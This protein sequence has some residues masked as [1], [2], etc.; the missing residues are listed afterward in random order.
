M[1]SRRNNLTIIFLVVGIGISVL[2]GGYAA[3]ADRKSTDQI[4]RSLQ[5]G[6][7]QA[8]GWDSDCKNYLQHGGA[9]S[10][11]DYMNAY[12][13]SGG[14][15]IL[16]SEG[17]NGDL[18]FPPYHDNA[19]GYR[20]DTWMSKRGQGNAV[21]PISVDYG[22]TSIPLQ[23]NDVMFLCGPL[24]NPDLAGIYHHGCRTNVSGAD[25][26]NDS[27]RWVRADD[28]NDRDPNGVVEGK[29]DPGSGCMYPAQS[30]SRRKVVSLVVVDSSWGGSA[31]IDVNNPLTNCGPDGAA[32]YG[33]TC[34]NIWRDIHSRYWIAPPVNF[35]Y[36][37]GRPID[38]SGTL[39]IQLHYKFFR[40][41]HSDIERN[42]TKICEISGLKVGR[43][44]Y[45]DI[46]RCPELT[47]DLYL[48]IVLNY[49]YTLSPGIATSPALLREGNPSIQ[50]Q[51][52][53]NNTGRT[54]SDNVHWYVSRFVVPPGGTY[55]KSD[56][57]APACT[58]F[59]G[60]APGSCT[61]IQDG[62]RT[63]PIG[64][65]YVP[66]PS[67]TDT[68]PGGTPIGS[69]ICYVTSVDKGST[70][71]PT[72]S[73]SSVSC[74]MIERIPFVQV[75][76][77]DLRVGSSFNGTNSRAGATSFVFDD[78]GSW[79]EY[80]ILAPGGVSGLASESA[81]H[82]GNGGAP[83]SWSSLTFANTGVGLCPSS[84]GCFD[85]ATN[86]G[87]IPSVG[88]FVKTATYKGAPLNYDQGSASF[89]ASD[90]PSIVSGTNL[91]S[92]TKAFSMT[93]T[94]D[95]TID[96]DITYA[97]GVLHSTGEIPQL[98]L[99]GRNINITGNVK[100]ID[101]WLVA[102]GTVNTCSD[103]AQTAL[104]A[105][106]CTNQ[107]TVNGAIMASQLL[108]DRTYHQVATPDNAAE[109]LNLRAD[110]YIWSSEAARQNG[111][112]QTVYTAELPPRY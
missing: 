48:S 1:F 56:A 38:E 82:G 84:F 35:T 47:T 89:K 66:G 64:T 45:L 103:V 91:D 23:I 28:A 57:A 6:M 33:N 15:G 42:A 37:S 21:V 18:E 58:Q 30:F 77:N 75:L 61:T 63:F 49:D 69:K 108:L 60:Y 8:Y 90:I 87:K 62:I 105:T 31:T 96:H 43:P 78:E 22:T 11:R 70:A 29:W 5:Y 112:W 53:V 10:G 51:A 74:S 92:F 109:T 12:F 46:N 44:S 107:L 24:V 17:I 81:A 76:G 88:S 95:I 4:E 80:G 111:Q 3:H 79:G 65:S 59:S 26:V 94:G 110:A 9:Y 50:V 27:S 55:S 71:S 40:A 14:M 98:I 86:M 32:T 13:N 39:H 52:N 20:F 73:H 93:T 67:F 34:T 25:I 72:W 85:T 16:R 54:A 68:I 99:V 19:A 97:S 36:Y 101:A 2:S 83:S 41:Y 100:H 102:T 104:R 106:T 7:N